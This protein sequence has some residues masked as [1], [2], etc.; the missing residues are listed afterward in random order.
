MG[1]PQVHFAKVRERGL[2]LIFIWRNC[3]YCSNGR[4]VGDISRS[5]L[6]SSVVKPMC[7][8]LHQGCFPHSEHLTQPRLSQADLKLRR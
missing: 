6:K 7:P 3:P 4:S 1:A 5:I 2:V 8:I